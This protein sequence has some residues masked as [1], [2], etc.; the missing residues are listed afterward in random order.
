MSEYTVITRPVS[1]SYA[2]AISRSPVPSAQ[3]LWSKPPQS[4]IRWSSASMSRPMALGAVKSS[5]VPAT[6]SSV[7]VGIRSSV[8]AVTCAALIFSTVESTS[9]EPSAFRLKKLWF[10]GLKTVFLSVVPR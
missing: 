3:K 9:F 2:S 8:T 4:W 1:G 6:G 10:V 7:P 5:G